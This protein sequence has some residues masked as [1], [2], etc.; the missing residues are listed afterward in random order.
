[1]DHAHLMAVQHGLQDLLNA[2]TACKYHGRPLVPAPA[3][4]AAAEG[5][6]A[7]PPRPALPRSERHGLSP[8]GLPSGT[9]GE[10]AALPLRG[11]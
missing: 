4:G 6:A 11:N 10:A 2:M 8:A 5:E 7:L 3:R 9:G 1:M